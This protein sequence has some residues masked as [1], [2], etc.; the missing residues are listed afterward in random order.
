MDIEIP[1]EE[2][3]KRL[4]KSIIKVS[5]ILVVIALAC[6]TLAILLG[7]KL[8]RKNI[9][10]GTVDRGPIEIAVT[11]SGKLVPLI[12]E[13]IV[14]P[15]NSRILE[16]YKNPGDTVYAGEP[17]LKLDLASVE[18]EYQ[19]KMDEREVMKSK[20]LQAEVKQNNSLSEIEMQQQL[21]EMRLRQLEADLKS[22]KHLESIGASTAD[23]VRRLELDCQEAKLRWA[24]LKQQNENEKKNTRAELRVQE[25]ELQILAKEL[26]EKARQLKDA[27]VL[28]PRAATLTFV[29]NQVGA[30]VNQGDQL[31]IVSDLS[32]YKAECE[33]SDRHRDKLVPGAP[34]MIQ[35]ADTQLKGAVYSIT[36]SIKN[37]LVNFTVLL[38]DSTVPGL[39][40]G[41]STDVYVSYGLRSD[42]LRIPNGK[43]YNGA[44]DY[45]LWVVKGKKAV[46]KKVKLG[47]SDFQY[48]EV[49]EGLSL[50]DQVI[51]SDMEP[52]K[53]KTEISLK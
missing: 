31:A 14:S 13:I 1:V 50:A 43:F 25:L 11:A 22:E 5:A 35:L 24:Q 4:R 53:N 34:A 3:R 23:K 2:R 17:L 7:S 49:T 10:V 16:V 33:I 40:S 45:Y 32:K 27:R 8:S 21:Q 19:Q 41:L 46:K 28:S 36:P 29:M 30:A 48:I 26:A 37:G 52:Y 47:E 18:T 51:I 6:I 42:V 39:R 44:G 9:T 15:I 20:M 38:N 12:E